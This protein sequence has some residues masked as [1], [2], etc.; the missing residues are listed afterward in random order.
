MHYHCF[1]ISPHHRHSTAIA[2]NTN[3]KKPPEGGFTTLL[4]ALIL[5][6]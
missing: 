5:F 1:C 6:L 4:I 2:Q 3:T